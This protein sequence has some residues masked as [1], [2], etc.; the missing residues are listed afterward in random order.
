MG[1]PAAEIESL[2]Q[3][4]IGADDE[5]ATEAAAK[6]G[7]ARTPRAAE[8]LLEVLAEGG[9]AVRVQAVLDAFA[10]LGEA[11]A[12]RADQA[13]IDALTLYAG[14]RSPDIRRRAVK[15]LASVPDPHVTAAL[16]ERLGDAAPDVRAAAAD[17]LAVRRE[18]K[19]VPR[20]FALLSRGDAGVGAALAALASPDLVPRIAELAGTIDDEIVANTLGEYVKRSDVPEKLRIDVLRTIGRL[21]GAVATTALAE[22][23]ASV[24]A[25]ED[26]ASKKE[27][28]KLLER[29]GDDPVTRGQLTFLAAL[30]VA[31]CAPSPYQ[32]AGNGDDIAA[33]V[34]RS[35]PPQ[36]GPRSLA[37]L[38]L[39][40]AAG[41]RLAAYDLTASRVLWTQPADVTVRVV[42][43]ASVLVHGSKATPPARPTGR[44]WDATSASGAVLWQHPI[45]SS[46]E[47]FGYALDGDEVYVVERVATSSGKPAGRLTALTAARARV[48]GSR[49]SRRRGWR[50]PPRAAGWSRCPPNPSTSCCTTAPRARPSDRCSRRKKRPPS[51][52]RCPRACSTA[53]AACS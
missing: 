14:H 35:R 6:L 40:G 25:K 48:A 20:L 21:S 16:L 37:F 41:P 7:E 49:R 53:R 1:L 8:P 12:L 2:R 51:C 45:A 42:S 10:K 36:S 15:A 38:V 4:L 30:A 50:R 11:H 47:L 9:R 44:S 34:S 33:A 13:V 22:Y 26:R 31:G 5:A 43:G 32:R 17:A 3:A 24:P 28:Q 23:L 18:A 39:G 52:A 46:E 29:A 27:A 19:A